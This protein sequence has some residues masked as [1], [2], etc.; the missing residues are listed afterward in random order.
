MSETKRNGE[1]F[2]GYDYKEIA[3]AGEQ[4]AFCLDC[5]QCLGWE[6]DDRPPAAKGP[7]RLLVQLNLAAKYI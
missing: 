1:T 4:A 5:Y 3:A 6:P 7:I 2:L